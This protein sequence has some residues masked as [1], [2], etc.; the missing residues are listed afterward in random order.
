MATVRVEKKLH[1]TLRELAKSEHR[2]I[3]K[4]IEDAVAKY[5][6][7]KFWKE[8]HEGFAR[9]RADPVAW[10]EY[11]DDAAVWD[12]MSSDG[13]ENEEPYYSPEEEAEIRAE[14]AKSQDR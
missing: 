1:D 6:K 8:M 7:D 4:V 11:Q 12:T 14:F 5:E 2:P 10:K 13:L 3:G 9:L